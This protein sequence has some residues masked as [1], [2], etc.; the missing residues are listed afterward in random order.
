MPR[1]RVIAFLA[2][3]VLLP[4]APHAQST[5]PSSTA[6]W[7]EQYRGLPQPSAMKESMRRLSARPHHVGS[8]YDK[9]NAEWLA[10]QFRAFGWQTEIETFDVLFPTPK[11][12]VLE[13]VE[14]THYTAS[15]DEPVV[16]QDP[17]SAQKNEQLPTYNAYSR[18][19]DVTA[20]LVY[21]NYGRPQDYEVLDRYGISVKGAIVIARYGESWRGIK[22]K[23]AAEKG[24]V[25]CLI[26]SDPINDG[27]SEDDV[28]PN[29]PMRP[30]HGVQRGS[31]A[32]MPTYAGDPLTPGVGATASAKRLPTADAPTLTKIPVLPISY[33]DARPLL[34]ALKGPVVPA[35]FRG[36]LPITYRFGPGPAKV[37]LKLAFNWDLK[38]LYDVIARIPGAT[39]PDEWI[40]RGNHH[41]AWVNGAEDPVSGMA[42]M[43]EEARGLGELVKRGWKP[44]RTIVYA[45]WDGEEPGLLGSTEWVEQHDEDLKKHAVVYINSDGNDRGFLDLSGSHTLEGFVNGVARVVDDPEA[46]VSAWQRL[47]ANRIANGTEE[48]RKTTRGRSNL[49]L[50]ALGSGSD[51]TPFLQHNGVPTLSVG[52]GGEDPGGIYHSIYDDF[53]WYMHFSDYDF[54]YGR[55][56]AQLAGSAVIELA[57]AGLLPFDFSDL[58]DAV[59]TYSTEVQT[60]LKTRQD[61]IREKNRQLD[62]GV[63]AA[64]VDPRRPQIAPPRDTVP[65][66]INF[67]PLENAATRLAAA[68]ARYTKA[69]TA[70][71][72]KLETSDSTVRSV[73]ALLMQSERQL[74]DPAGLPKREWYRHLIY[75]PGYYTGYS[76]KTLPGIR[77]GIEQKDYAGAE[78][79]VVRA[80]AA[81]DRESELIEK[82]AGLLESLR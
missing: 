38:P 71:G 23:V 56:L 63:F 67:A 57:D 4:V 43:L 15:L 39:Y 70:A 74:I 46:H 28:F 54:V 30:G 44:K 49:R 52:F 31:V 9:D 7:A 12:R 19:G 61:E 55:A 40:I 37:H 29:G 16:P 58:S 51:F 8:P 26:Y 78:K 36:G 20:P 25:G 72:A 6:S 73:N 10:A 77:E 45:A 60:L 62:D 18:D 65:P 14:P 5:K 41:D 66:A 53:Y 22:P 50:D 59:A 42:A 80:A 68:A 3:A 82:A 81:L 32:D 34:L 13:L 11:E 21:V 17:T 35:E 48:V 69:R 76:V 79:E 2:A 47:Q 75:A 33:D 1:R 27:Y 24:A 64:M